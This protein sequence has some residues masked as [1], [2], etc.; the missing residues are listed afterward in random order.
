M[1]TAGSMEDDD[2]PPP[3]AAANGAPGEEPSKADLW[4]QTLQV[5][6]SNKLGK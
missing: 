4:Q 1:M 5:M 2:R 6:M 3:P